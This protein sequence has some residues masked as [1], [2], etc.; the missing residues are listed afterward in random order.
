MTKV[1]VQNHWQ[2]FPAA[3]LWE[4]MGDKLGIPRRA[5]VAQDLYQSV[6]TAN[7]FS[8]QVC[9]LFTSQTFCITVFIVDSVLS[10]SLSDM[11]PGSF[12]CSGTLTGVNFCAAVLHL[13][14]HVYLSFLSIFAKTRL[15]DSSSQYLFWNSLCEPLHMNSLS[16][17]LNSPVFS[18]KEDFISLY[19]DGT[20]Y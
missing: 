19:A 2:W 15:V 5:S 11:T 9:F 16:W 1:S 7:G 8:I 17:W 20:I 4:V 12:V 14:W 13:F 18:E 6:V 10:T 3:L